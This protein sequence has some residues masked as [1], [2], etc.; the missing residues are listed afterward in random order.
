MW[1]RKEILFYVGCTLGDRMAF[2][3]RVCFKCGEEMASLHLAL[4]EPDLLHFLFIIK[5]NMFFFVYFK[6]L[7][8]CPARISAKIGY[9]KGV[10]DVRS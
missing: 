7:K 8:D 2:P 1:Q 9:D 5:H 6:M 3:A 4:V 10:P